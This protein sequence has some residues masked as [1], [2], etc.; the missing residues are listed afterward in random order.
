MALAPNH[1]ALNAAVPAMN[2]EGLMEA[3]LRLS[4]LMAQESIMLSDMRYQ[5]MAALQEEKRSLTKLMESYQMQLASN[6]EFLQ[7]LD[8]AQREELIML[9]DDLAV[10][11]TENF[12]K[13]SAARAVNQ[14]VLQAM[15]DVISESHRPGTY[16]RNGMAHTSSD[17]AMSINLNQKA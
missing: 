11:V 9:A 12:R 7:R 15:R 10:N 17:L 4:D 13:V 6:P 2:I 1:F 16:G 3:T 8:P 14:R 5:D